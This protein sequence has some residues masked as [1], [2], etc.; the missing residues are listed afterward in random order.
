MAK[1]REANKSDLETLRK[2][3]DFAR[4][5]EILKPFALKYTVLIT[6]LDAPIG[7]HFTITMVNKMQ[8]LGL[9]PFSVQM[10]RRAYAAVIHDG[11]KL[12]EKV[13]DDEMACVNYKGEIN[14]TPIIIN[15]MGFSNS[16]LSGTDKSKL[17]IFIDNQKQIPEERGMHIV[18]FDPD[19]KTILDICNFDSFAQPRCTHYGD[20]SLDAVKQSFLS[21]IGLHP[22]VTVLSCNIPLFP[23]RHLTENEQHIIDDNIDSF[24]IMAN[25]DNPQYTVLHKYIAS[26]DEITDLIYQHESELDLYGVPQFKDKNSRLFNCRNGLRV[27][28]DQPVKHERTLYYVG[29]SYAVGCG[30]SDRG[31]L[32]SHLQR[33]F[34][35]LAFEQGMIVHNYG[36]YYQKG[37]GSNKQLLLNKIM[38]M[39]VAAAGGGYHFSS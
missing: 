10:Y 28:T 36:C 16:K 35:T 29:P 33:L 23:T 14:G 13:G 32:A 11:C 9:M 8:Q 31:T 39:P 15:S 24:R 37:A 3:T 18:L 21:W 27:T 5:L 4:Y 2:E 1:H 12:F 25:K 34:N 30:S 7:P 38:S 6:A 26:S 22:E 20:I 19:A 17:G